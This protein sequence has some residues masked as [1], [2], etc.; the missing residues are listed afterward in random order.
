MDRSSTKNSGWFAVHLRG[1]GIHPT[2]CSCRSHG[3]RKM[4]CW[5][6]T[7]EKG[8]DEINDMLSCCYIVLKWS[9]AKIIKKCGANSKHI[10]LSEFD[11]VMA[12]SAKNNVTLCGW[13]IS[14]D[15]WPTV[16]LHGPCQKDKQLYRI[17]EIILKNSLVS[18]PW[19]SKVFNL[20]TSELPKPSCNMGD[21]LVDL[22]D[23][24][25]KLHILTRLRGLDKSTPPEIRKLQGQASWNSKSGFA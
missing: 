22:S 24:G 5:H 6:L 19:E 25:A 2:W 7:D 1:R 11:Y 13:S 9:K 20:W 3:S 4:R 8:R 18:G 15:G 21:F 23:L 10:K 16:T 12:Q 14:L 17:T